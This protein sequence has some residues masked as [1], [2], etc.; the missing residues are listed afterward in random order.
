MPPQYSPPP[1]AAAVSDGDGCLSGILLPPLAVLFVSAVLAFLLLGPVGVTVTA[2][3]TLPAPAG[4]VP[5]HAAETSLE[6][7]STSSEE[8]PPLSPIFTPEVQHWADSILRW[9]AAAGLDPNLAATVMQI[10]SCG[11]PRALSRAGATGL[12]QVMPYHFTAGEN[13]YDPD[14]NAYRGLNYLSRSLTK[15][16]GNI[17]LTLA[18]YNGG[19]GVIERPESTWA[20]ETIRYAAWGSGIYADAF[21]GAEES[22]RLQEWLLSNGA[23]LCRQAAE[24][25]GLVP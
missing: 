20:R 3:E 4:L 13:P 15:A 5:E 25:L 23:S 12:F 14:T 18:G 7:V 8:P 17:R 9:A 24:R 1:S 21:S 2:S 16:G 19:V 10:E 6:P 11:D 22:S